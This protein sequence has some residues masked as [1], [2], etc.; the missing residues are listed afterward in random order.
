M[1]METWKAKYYPIDAAT[2]A[3][4]MKKRRETERDAALK[5]GDYYGGLSK[6]PTDH[7]LK[8]KWTDWVKQRA[9]THLRADLISHSLRKW[10]GFL[11]DALAKHEITSQQL[12]WEFSSGTAC[13]LCQVYGRSTRMGKPCTQCPLMLVSGDEVKD[14]GY[15]T[16]VSAYRKYGA[17]KDPRPLISKLELANERALVELRV[18]NTKIRAIYA[19]ANELVHSMKKAPNVKFD[20][21]SPCAKSAPNA[22]TPSFDDIYGT[23][24]VLPNRGIGTWTQEFYPVNVATRCSEVMLHAETKY[25]ECAER[26]NKIVNGELTECI[27]KYFQ[28]RLDIEYQIQSVQADI[29]LMEHALRKWIGARPEEI[30]KHGLSRRGN[31]ILDSDDKVVTFTVDTCSLCARYQACCSME[32]DK[33]TRDRLRTCP[34]L[35]YSEEPPARPVDNRRC[36]M[37]YSS[38]FSEEGPEPMIQ[39]MTRI[40]GALR[41]ELTR[42]KVLASCLDKQIEEYQ[43][44]KIDTMNKMN[45][46]GHDEH[47][48]RYEIG[49]DR[50]EEDK[51]TPDV[52][53][54]LKQYN[55]NIA[56]PHILAAY[57]E[58]LHHGVKFGSIECPFC[59]EQLTEKDTEMVNPVVFESGNRIRPRREVT[60]S[61]CGARWYEIYLLGQLEEVRRPK[62]VTCKE[63]APLPPGSTGFKIQ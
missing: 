45:N 53:A 40:T 20:L 59:A 25:Q 23:Y 9:N 18:I 22:E 57:I 35:R 48:S 43:M 38:L 28:Q 3:E 52:I 19:E 62:K 36:I 61:K 56:S 13:A 46:M 15:S 47:H 24:A 12:A 31:N 10:R 51:P 32:T 26:L 1:S 54:D 63:S 60:C 16:C 39:E 21:N 42:L 34:L 11:P 37:E 14:V 29:Y 27:P 49:V 17:T 58:K 30:K 44:S 55:T 50:A 8:N 4:L 6:L 5:R 41:E 33:R 2:Y 7:P